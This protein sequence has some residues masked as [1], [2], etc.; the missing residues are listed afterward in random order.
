MSLESAGRERERHPW[1]APLVVGVVALLLGLAHLLGIRHSPFFAHPIVDAFDYDTDAWHIV[2]SG[3]WAG[4]GTVYFQAPLFVYFLAVVYKVFGHDLWWPRLVQVVIG[5]LSVAGALLV[6]RRLFGERAGWVTGAGAAVYSLLI[7]F[8]GEL[9]APTLT[10]FLDV[11]MLLVLF[12]VAWPRS[13]WAWAAPGLL[14][15]LRALATTNN[16]AVTPVL[17][18]AAVLLGRRRGWT[19]RQTAMTVAAFT[20]G[21]AVALAPVTL[22]NWAVAGQPTLVSS[23]AGLN[24]YLGNS[25]DYDSKVGL[26]PGPEWEELM[27][28]P[29]RAGARTESQMSAYYFGEAWKYIRAHP[30]QY[31]GMLAHKV[32]LLL[33]GDEILRNQDIY[34]F[35]EH[36]PVLR[37]LLWKVGLPGGPGLAFPFGLLL[38]LAW[39]GLV[40][41]LRDR[42]LEGGLLVAFVV[43]YSLSVVTFF[44]TARYRL[45]LVV[46][47]LILTGYGLT[48]ARGLWSVPRLRAVALAGVIGLGLVSNWSPG[49]MPR[50]ASPDAYFSLAATFAAKGDLAGAERYYKE[51]ISL[52][53][54]DAGSWL[55]LGLEVY[56]AQGRLAEAEASYR[57]A[58][59]VR[60]GY[61]LAV[62]NLGRL[63]EMRGRPAEAESLY[64]EASRLDPLM[65]GPHHNLAAMALAGGDYRRARDLYREALERNP[66]SVSILA[67]LAVAIFKTD[68]LEPALALFEEA[69]AIDPRDPDVYYNLALVNL[70]A[71]RPGPA[72]EAAERLIELA[73]EDDQA[74]ELYARAVRAAGR[75]DEARRALTDLARRR[76]DLAGPRWALEVLGA[77]GAGRD[78]QPR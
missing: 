74:Y 48:R 53:P 45:P 5:S 43:V 44:V 4:G 39:L 78:P 68:G 57:R 60:P 62:F 73:P 23:N 66:L 8:Q 18:A 46:P 35:R 22:R 65:P 6:A 12:S 15:G 28:R 75:V 61:G 17:W 59:S 27:N 70:Q 52:N 11:A 36:S 33:K 41:T 63:A 37:L 40:A 9:L 34:P 49:V 13:G 10:V 51:A 67:G 38:P 24:F 55:N 25:G 54:R 64:W 21:M 42:S 19:G 2:Q 16:L 3:G 7:Y 77:G 69:V 32:H 76:P 14:F 1:L 71:G 58:L 72:A 30:G 20:V 29:L 50:D 31:L 47:L 56:L 26:R